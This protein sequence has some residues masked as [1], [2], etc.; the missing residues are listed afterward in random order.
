MRI[1]QLMSVLLLGVVPCV[2]LA[3][4]AEPKPFKAS[5]IHAPVHRALAGKALKI[6]ALVQGDWTL[7]PVVLRY[8]MVGEPA[9]KAVPF[10]RTG[11][12]WFAKV[13]A[14]E[15]RGAG[16]AYAIE[17]TGP[18]GVVHRHF[19]S[20]EVPHVI[21]VHGQSE[22]D[23]RARRLAAYDGHRSRLALR[24]EAFAYGAVLH[25][26]G[27]DGGPSETDRFSDQYWRTELEY[28][29]R[30]L[31]DQLHDFRF[32]VGVL[33]GAWPEVNDVAISEADAPGINYGFGELNFELLYWLSVGGR[34]VLGAS[35]QG[36]V[37]GL[38]GVVRLGPMG[39]T[40]L[41]VKV[42]G[43]GDV[44]TRTDLRLHWDTVPNMPMALGIE[45]TDWPA[46][47]DSGDA[48]NLSYDVG[49]EFGTQWTLMARVGSAKRTASLN[50][51]WQAGLGLL[52]DF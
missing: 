39:G 16:L 28:T 13:P 45:L 2:A 22:E 30:T 38:G 33:R 23:R 4:P 52:Y 14:R 26:P 34:L 50:G 6:K 25:A 7:G 10:E 5:V 21:Q 32:G 42:E 27:V 48:A 46:S 19:A 20:T 51:G 47:D 3:K 31:G 17:S 29:Y 24:G 43:I 18:D 12:H 49:Y 15:V 8:R 37:A 35:D 44:G 41:A 40:H 36:F 1:Q 9:F 11:K